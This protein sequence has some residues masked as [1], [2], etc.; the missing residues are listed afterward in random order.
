MYPSW[1]DGLVFSS[2][3]RLRL[4]RGLAYRDFSF[5]DFGTPVVRVFDIPNSLYPKSQYLK[6]SPTFEISAFRISRFR[7]SYGEVFLH[8]NSR[9]PKL[10]PA[11]RISAFRI[12]QFRDS[13]GEVFR[14]FNSRFLK[15]SP[16]FR[17]SSFCISRFQDSYGEVF[18]HFHLP[19]FETPKWS[20]INLSLIFL[21]CLFAIK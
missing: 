16:S 9:F 14:H 21:V 13:C 5:R 3:Q 7:D 18:R 19:V 1:I 4:Y 10:S 11:F 12:S 15:L 20:R 8:F 6:L 2:I 17:I